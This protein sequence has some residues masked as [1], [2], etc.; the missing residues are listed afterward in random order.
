[1]NL[2]FEW[3]EKYLTHSFQRF[4]QLLDATL[5]K[6]KWRNHSTKTQPVCKECWWDWDL[7]CER[8]PLA[9]HTDTLSVIPSTANISKSNSLRRLPNRDR[10]RAEE[11]KPKAAREHREPLSWGDNQRNHTNSTLRSHRRWMPEDKSVI[12]ESLSPYWN[13]R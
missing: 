8:G 12:S 5:S 2:M 1:M 9:S 7:T 10:I 6:P 4:N 13:Q 11:Q 3:Q